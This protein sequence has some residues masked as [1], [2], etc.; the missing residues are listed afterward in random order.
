MTLTITYRPRSELRP[1]KANPRTHTPQ[2]VAQIAASIKEFG[3]TNPVLIDADSNVIA[4]HGRIQAA[5]QLGL[6]EVPT[7]ALADLTPT[8]A[9]AYVIADNRLALSAGW[10]NDLLRVELSELKLGDFDLSLLG[11]DDKELVALLKPLTGSEDEVPEP[12][13]VPVAQRGNIYKLGRHRLMCGDATDKADVER[14]L[15]GITPL[16]MVTDPPY[17][18]EYDA[19]WRNE[20]AAKGQLSYAASRVGKVQNDNRADWSEAWALFPGDVVYC[21][22]AAGDLMVTSGQALIASGFQI[23]ASLIW[24]KPNFPISRGHYTFQHEPCWYAVRKGRTAHWQGDHTQSTVWEA[25]LDKNVEGG[26]STQKPVAVMERPIKNH[27]S[28]Y[29]YDPFC[30]TGTTIIAAE[31]QNRA[32]YAM[33]IDPQWID[34]AVKRWEKYTGGKAEKL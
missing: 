4:G 31:R 29:V 10:D 27:D 3:W 12:P 32:C 15:A 26:H 7:I 17:G 9:R 2:Q 14:L 18:V 16:L 13:A 21:W 30:G 25:S 11:F 6:N 5:E 28:D 20:A 19:N 1:Q 24:K 34:V 33:D 8:Q 23:R 22:C